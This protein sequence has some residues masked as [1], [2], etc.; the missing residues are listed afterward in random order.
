MTSAKGME[1]WAV[2]A[3]RLAHTGINSNFMSYS[4]RRQS[5]PANK[6]EAQNPC[7]RTIGIDV[8]SSTIK[9]AFWYWACFVL[10][11]L[12][13][14]VCAGQDARLVELRLPAHFDPYSMDAADQ[15]A[16]AAGT[17]CAVPKVTGF[18]GY[19]WR[20]PA[21]AAELRQR[22]GQS[23]GKQVYINFLKSKYGYRIAAV[24]ADFATDAQSFTELL[25]SP[26]RSQSPNFDPEFDAPARRDMVEGILKALR[27]C[28]ESHAA[29]G[30]LFL[31][32]SY[33]R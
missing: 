30:L 1:A 10:M 5:A 20:L 15:Y 3:T 33:L 13:N 9:T 23:P 16:A 2:P 4:V 11:L 32:E 21:V 24:N 7:T 17:A 26:I 25:E 27:T 29:S 31:V 6:P 19:F 18:I 28:D 22:S 12:V 14:A 8:T